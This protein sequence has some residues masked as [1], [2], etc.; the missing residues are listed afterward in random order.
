MGFKN[1]SHFYF[2]IIIIIF[3]IIMIRLTNETIHDFLTEEQMLHLTE[4]GIDTSDARYSIVSANIAPLNKFIVYTQKLTSSSSWKDSIPNPQDFTFIC[5][6]YTLADLL[7]K[8]TEWVGDD[9][10]K[11]L[12]FFKD[13]PYYCFFYQNNDSRKV[14]DSCVYDETPLS[15]AYN[16]LC[17]CIEHNYGY[18]KNISGK[19]SGEH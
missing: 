5:N 16:L 4:L 7:Y 6:T 14:D 19:Y 2:Y 17:W 8:L 15:A 12:S 9:G 13:A 1:K 3:F 18:V 11:G 10:Y